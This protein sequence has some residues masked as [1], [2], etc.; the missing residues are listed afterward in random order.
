M[1]HN[2]GSKNNIII[3]CINVLQQYFGSGLFRHLL[4][5]FLS[6]KTPD[7]SLPRTAPGVTAP[8]EF[9]LKQLTTHRSQG[10]D[11]LTFC[12]VFGQTCLSFP[13]TKVNVKASKVR[14]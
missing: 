6:M 5:E 13:K 7:N 10:D 1:Y 11:I 4:N 14:S 3:H 12:D 2:V 8:P 9:I